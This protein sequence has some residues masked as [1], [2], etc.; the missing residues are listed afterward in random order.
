MKPIR[1]L[2]TVL[3]AAPLIALATAGTAHADTLY[4]DDV[5]YGVKQPIPISECRADGST[6]RIDSDGEQHHQR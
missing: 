6:C 1:S 4:I 5:Q 2:L 3:A